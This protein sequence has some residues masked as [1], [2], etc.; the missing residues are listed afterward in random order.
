MKRSSGPRQTAN[1][2]QSIQQRLNMYVIAASTVGV[3]VFCSVQPSDAKIVYTPADAGPV[4]FAKFTGYAHE[5]VASKSIKAGETEGPADNAKRNPGF[6]SFDRPVA[7]TPLNSPLGDVPLWLPKKTQ[8][9]IG[10]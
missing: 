4:I 2:S 10:Q 1:L 9:V 3:S 6:A 7:A 5:T 8:K